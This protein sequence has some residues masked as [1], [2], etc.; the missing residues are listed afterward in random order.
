MGYVGRGIS[1]WLGSTVQVQDIEPG[2]EPAAE[3]ENW[4]D[5]LVVRGQVEGIATSDLRRMI[6]EARS[7]GV[8]TIGFVAEKADAA[9]RDVVDITV[10]P[11]GGVYGDVDIELHPLV[12]LGQISPIGAVPPVEPGSV[13]ALRS[14]PRWSPRSTFRGFDRMLDLETSDRIARHRT[15]TL[16]SLG[17]RPDIAPMLEMLRQT[18]GVVDDASLHTSTSLRAWYLA[19][20]AVAGVPFRVLDQSPDAIEAQIGFDLWQTAR[21]SVDSL[22]D[23]VERERISVRQRRIGLDRFTDW[24]RWSAIAGLL[25]L[26]TRGWPTISVILSTNRPVQLGHALDQIRAQTYQPVE[27]IV[28]LHGAGFDD[29]AARLVA[30]RC[31]DARIVSV[32]ERESLGDA[33]NAGVAAATGELVTKMDDDDWYGAD[34]LVDLVHAME[35]SNA[36]LVGK[37]AEWVYLDELDMTMRRFD[38]GAESTSATLA[39]GTM[40]IRRADLLAVGGFRRARRHVDLGLI[41]DVGRLGG[42]TYRTHGFG[43]LLNRRSGGHT[44]DIGVDYFLEQ[45]STQVRGLSRDA[46]MTQIIDQTGRSQPETPE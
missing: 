27:P 6:I 32:D 13:V 28:V 44:W 2:W 23:P 42:G 1:P 12:D 15:L 39:G 36:T 19:Q 20:L 46:S 41:D 40:L 17:R 7:A 10:G 33:L 38:T 11:V 29:G 37:A 43:Y 3:A 24:A 4:V 21:G 14:R 22:F 30:E 35:Y 45:S 25:G 18:G 31:P 8:R 5:V 16:G 34:H 26:P 9:I